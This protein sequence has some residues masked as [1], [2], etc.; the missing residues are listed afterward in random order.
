MFPILKKS[1]KTG[2]VTGQHPKAEASQEPISPEAAQ[3]TKPFRRSLAIR[4][5][6]QAPAMPARWR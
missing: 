6:V 4:E 1:L 3:K 2:V 5:V